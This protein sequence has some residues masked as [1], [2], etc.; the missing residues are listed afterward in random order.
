MRAL[1]RIGFALAHP[2]RATILGELLSGRF[3]P[4]G[5][6][7]RIATATPSTASE[8]LAILADAGLVRVTTV[9]RHRYYALASDEVART[10]ET[11]AQWRK[12]P[13]RER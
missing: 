7:A 2:L 12:P 10:L 6:L 11:W 4:S 3:L 13:R 8:Q 5:E 1:D 9:G